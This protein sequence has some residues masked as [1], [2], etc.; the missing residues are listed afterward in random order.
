MSAGR[1]PKPSARLDAI[2]KTA[3][4]G[5]ETDPD[6]VSGKRLTYTDETGKKRYQFVERRRSTAGEVEYRR[7][8]VYLMTMR[9]VPR[10]TQADVLGVSIHIIENDILENKQRMKREVYEMDFPLFLAETL[11]FYKEMRSAALNIAYDESI[12]K[13][14][15]T[16]I[17]AMTLALQ[18]ESDKHKF[19]EAAGFYKAV[20]EAESSKELPML[21]RE[22]TDDEDFNSLVTVLK[23]KIITV[24]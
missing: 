20:R 11:C 7:H 17:S 2:P 18:A 23:D 10:V 16:K 13:D 3:K 14:Y 15:K 6:K 22:T 9:G 1:I 19:L 8:Q 12:G 4:Y 24:K 5:A 21:N